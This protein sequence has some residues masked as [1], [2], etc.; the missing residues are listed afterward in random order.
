MLSFIPVYL[1]TS[2]PLIQGIAKLH[3]CNIDD[4]EFIN[5]KGLKVKFSKDNVFNNVLL[6]AVGWLADDFQKAFTDR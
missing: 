3:T 6:T 4:S 2:R 1:S 5:K